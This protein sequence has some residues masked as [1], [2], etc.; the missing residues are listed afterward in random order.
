MHNILLQSLILEFSWKE[1]RVECLVGMI[2]SLIEHCSVSG[3][4]MALGLKGEAKHNSKTQRIYRFFRD[5]IFNYDQVAKFILNIFTNDK[6]I[7]A[8]DRTCW[9]FGK[10]NINILFLVIVFGKISVPVYWYPLDHGGACGSWLMEE[11]LERFINN[12]GVHKIKYLLADREF[13]SK[14]WLDFLTKKQIKFAIPLRKDMKIRIAR[15]LQIKQVGKSFDYLKPYE[16]IE[17]KGI[18]WGHVVTLSAYRNDKN[19]LMVVAAGG[20]IDV[21]I[22][23]LYKFRWAI[24]RLFKHLKSA[25]FDIEKS[26]I[27]D[28]DRFVKLLAVCAIASALIIKNGLIQ[29]EINPIKI[30]DHKNKPRLLVSFFTY[31]FDHIRNCLKQT[32]NKAIAVIKR[33]LEYD[34]ITNFDCYFNELLLKL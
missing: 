18:L 4:N 22:F 11:I 13:M 6:Y 3:K 12:V 21:S 30:R 1:S 23:S 24:E 19:E 25:G 26:H 29:N 15:A 33:I 31:G 10:S 8:L 9:K 32:A 28:P 16:Y 2:I 20:D 5:Q 27:T 17:V 7:I 14:E 34:S